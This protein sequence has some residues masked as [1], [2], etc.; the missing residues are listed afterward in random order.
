MP[1]TA[2]TATVNLKMYHRFLR[3]TLTIIDLSYDT[4]QYVLSTVL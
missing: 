1:R 4:V 2:E 3:P